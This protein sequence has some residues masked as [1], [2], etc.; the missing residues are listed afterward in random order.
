MNHIA[1]LTITFS[2]L[3]VAWTARAQSP[4]QYERAAEKSFAAKDYY[5]ALQYYRNALAFDSSRADVWYGYAQSARLFGSYQCAAESY[6]RTLELD[7]KKQ[8][9]QA[10]YWLASVKKN[11]SDY[12]AALSL[13]KQFLAQPNGD[14]TLRQAAERE[15]DDCEWALE[16]ITNPDPNVL[17]ERLPAS[18]NTEQSDFGATLRGDTLYYSSFR[19]MDWKDRHYPARPIVKVMESLPGREPAPAPFNL[20]DRHTAHAAFSP[21]GQLMIFNQCDYKG[22]T[23]VVCE[24]YLSR[25]TAAGDWSSPVK[26]PETINVAGFTATQPNIGRDDDGYYELYFVSD[27][28]GGKGGLDLWRAR[29]SLA[30]NFA[31]PENLGALNTPENDVTPFFDSKYKTLYFSSL[32]YQNLGGY[33]IYKTAQT[34]AGWQT[35]EHLP[36]PLNS[37]YHDVYYAPQNEDMAYFT[38]N[39][40]GSIVYT[41]D[42]CCYD[43][44]KASAL[45]ISLEALAFS[46]LTQENLDEVLFTLTEMPGERTPISQFSGDGNQAGFDVQRRHT[47]QII[48]NRDGYLPDTAYVT[49]DLVP[50]SRKFVEKLYLTPDVGLQVRTFNKLTSEPLYGVH[51]RLIEITGTFSTETN[52]GEE[53]NE[54][55][56]RVERKRQYMIIGHKDGFTGDTTYVVAGELQAAK[57]GAII[58][59]KLNLTPASMALYLPLTLYFDNDKPS[60]NIKP[61]ETNTAYDQAYRAYMERREVFVDRYTR[62]LAGEEKQAATRRMNDFF[63]SNVHGGYMRLDSFASNLTLF[64]EGGANVEIMVKAYA[65][66][67]ATDAYNLA[68]TKRRIVSVLHYMRGYDGGIFEKYI[69][70]GQLKVSTVPFGEGESA[71]GVSDNPKDVRRSIYSPEASMERRAEILEVR[72]STGN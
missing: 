5:S 58:L 17:V 3:A 36:V 44:Y 9:P 56:L 64:L 13:Y 55:D 48:A 68:L 18:P 29:F 51:I 46:D 2:L 62:N 26:L 8:F 33:D 37:S 54:T 61:E 50:T 31:N 25:R 7:A 43:L 12:Y 52:T 71:G 69:L 23:E 27:R 38:S 11:L 47:Y 35:P 39:R 10:I 15:L 32:G 70:N 65:S 59:K 45:P 53:N 49:T 66:P 34:S 60:W 1:R 16:Q 42:A 57:P 30:G 72:L 19:E 24:L 6:A 22:E 28:P 41:E 67:L 20:D 40:E 21:D 14:L 63:D 4:K